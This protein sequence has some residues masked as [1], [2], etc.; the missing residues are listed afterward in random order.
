MNGNECGGQIGQLEGNG[1]DR[2]E[3]ED[4]I[5]QCENLENILWFGGGMELQLPV[6]VQL[7]EREIK[8]RRKGFN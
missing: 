7:R 3:E 6:S 5:C 2:Q 8:E 4:E 1:G